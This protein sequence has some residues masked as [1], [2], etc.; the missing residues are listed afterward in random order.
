MVRVTD[1]ARND[2]KCVEGPYNRNQTKIVLVS[3]CLRF[4]SYKIVIVMA[5]I[6]AKIHL[7]I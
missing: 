6:I 7:S 3:V 1:R 5:V 4:L 2:Q